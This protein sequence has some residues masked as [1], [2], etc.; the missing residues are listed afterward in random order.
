[1]TT[2]PSDLFDTN[3]N[4]DTFYRTFYSCAIVSGDAPDLW[5]THSGATGTECFATDIELYNYEF[6][7]TDW[8]G[9]GYEVAVSYT[10]NAP[11]TF[12]PSVTSIQTVNWS[13]SGFSDQLTNNANFTGLSGATLYG[14]LSNSNITGITTIDMADEYLVGN[15]NLV[16]LTNVTDF[17]FYGNSELTGLTFPSTNVVIT[18]IQLS[19]CSLGVLNW[20]DLSGQT[21][22]D[23]IINMDDNN[24]TTAEVNETLVLL[25]QTTWTGGTISLSGANDGYD[26]GTGGFD[27]TTAIANL[28]GK[29]WNATINLAHVVE[30]GYWNDDGFWVDTSPWLDDTYDLI[31][32]YRTVYNSMTTK[33]SESV[34]L[35]Q[36]TLVESLVNAGVWDKLDVFYNFANEINTAGEAQ[37]NWKTP[38]TRNATLVNSPIFTSL[39]GFST[40]GSSSYINTNY[41]P[42]THRVNY[43]LNSAS[44]FVYPTT[45]TEPLTQSMY[46]IGVLGGPSSGYI[47]ANFY[48]D[49]MARVELNTNVDWTVSSSQYTGFFVL[50]RT[51]SN[52]TTLYRNKTSLGSTSAASADYPATT[53]YVGCLHHYFSGATSFARK[54]YAFAGAGASLSVDEITV[55]TDACNTYLSS[56]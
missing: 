27:G 3:L 32:E 35:A 43:S 44:M 55:L 19:G 12:T 29:G 48:S 39:A 1:L 18:N 53:L 2:I 25:D 41:T 49:N 14:E 54:R 47:S 33:P 17:V 20:E 23:I 9:L 26:S 13:L 42:S 10:T 52:S 50:N 36:N 45:V 21:C 37:I 16:G 34:T 30:M 40:N 15:V 8:G 22:D 31:E 51:A 7:P 28:L 11:S 6:I 56:T 5:I 24:M 38:G 4:V 46:D